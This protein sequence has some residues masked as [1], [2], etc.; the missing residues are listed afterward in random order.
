M[1]RGTKSKGKKVRRSELLY[2]CKS[3]NIPAISKVTLNRLQS[4]LIR[5]NEANKALIQ[6]SFSKKCQLGKPGKEGTTYLVIDEKGSEYAMKT[7]RSTKSPRMVVAESRY[8]QEAW[9]VGA[10]PRVYSIG[11]CHIVMHPLVQPIYRVELTAKVQ[12]DVINLHQRLH[13]I[14]LVHNDGNPRNIMLSESGDMYLIDFGMTRRYTSKEIKSKEEV[15]VQI[16]LFGLMIY[17]HDLGYD[18]IK[19]EEW[20]N[21]LS[22]DWKRILIDYI[23]TGGKRK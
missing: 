4:I 18:V 14:Q 8:Q 3:L 5:I 23:N 9:T 15:A 10:A 7:F 6:S 2:K 13:K 17:L 16:G 12:L 11:E 21:Y 19:L 20:M 22:T 1:N